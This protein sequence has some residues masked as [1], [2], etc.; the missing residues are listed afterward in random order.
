MTEHKSI[1]ILN[2]VSGQLLVAMPHIGDNRFFHSVILMCQH[3]GEAAM[4]LV[5]NQPISNLSLD[6]LTEQLERPVARFDGEAPIFH[7]GP[8]EGGR[9]FV[10][11][12]TDHMLKDSLPIGDDLAMSFQLSIIDDI[13]AGTGPRKH[14][15]MLGYAGWEAGQLEAELREG[16]WFHLPA[17]KALVFDTQP[18]ELWTRCFHESGIDAA[19]LSPQAGS[20]KPPD[21]L[22]DHHLT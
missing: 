7:G 20:A 13:A 5:L 18:E 3:D 9:G 8:V 15:I 11:H 19:F 12:S 2:S 4:G 16:V 10:V 21:G 1:E 22:L 17:T 14:R 6:D